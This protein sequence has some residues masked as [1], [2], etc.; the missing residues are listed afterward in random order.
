MIPNVICLFVSR[1]LG[2]NERFAYIGL[3]DGYNGKTASTQC[4]DHLHEAILFELA[5]FLPQMKSSDAEQTLINRLYT[6]MI[7]P[8]KLSHETIENIGD[9]FRLS[10]SKMDYL[11]SRGLHETSPVRWSGTSALTAVVVANDNLEE[12]VMN[13]DEEK[14]ENMQIAFGHIHIANCG[15]SKHDQQSFPSHCS[16][17]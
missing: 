2:G 16:S 12:F 6:R 7:D 15:K 9:A 8:T 5:K 13:E 14:E 3:F 10:Y 4:R 11:L 17:L 1:S